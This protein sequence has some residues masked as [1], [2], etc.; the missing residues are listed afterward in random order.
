MTENEKLISSVN[1]HQKRA[2]R[3]PLTCGKDSN[4]APLVAREQNGQV[5]LF[6]EDCDYVQNW[7][8]S[9]FMES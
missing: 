7:V 5:K 4:H 8:P 9:Y 6:C 3:H 1:E 2:D